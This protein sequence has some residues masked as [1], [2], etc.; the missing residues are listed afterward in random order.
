MVEL[1]DANGNEV[2]KRE[3]DRSTVF[4]VIQNISC[5]GRCNPTMVEKILEDQKVTGE[6]E[7]EAAI[8]SSEVIDFTNFQ[9]AVMELGYPIG[10]ARQLLT[11]A[12]DV[13]MTTHPEQ[14]LVRDKPK[15]YP[16]VAAF[17]TKPPIPVTT[18]K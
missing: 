12:S 8:L 16:I 14:I 5:Q 9:L 18:S 7:R 11:D 17:R 10:T 15:Y 1:N 4:N 3:R 2:G 6:P 13:F